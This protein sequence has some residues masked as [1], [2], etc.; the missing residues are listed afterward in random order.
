MTS[1]QEKL[2]QHRCHDTLRSRCFAWGCSHYDHRLDLRY[3]HLKTALFAG[4]RGRVLEIGAGAGVN[5]HYFT[6]QVEFLAVEPNPHMRKYLHRAA[7]EAGL[8][9]QIQAGCAEALPIEDNT[10]DT[11]ISTLVLCSVDD[12]QQ[13]LAEVR[14]VLKPG[15]QFCFIEHVAAPEG[16]FQNRLQHLTAPLWRFFGDGCNPHRKTGAAIEH[17]GFGQ[18]DYRHEQIPGVRLVSPHIVGFAK[19]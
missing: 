13:A 4:L 9:V 12:P 1:R 15:G 5:L 16:T 2:R 7:Q 8:K 11:V 6:E 17:A 18:V 3:A 14:R 19:K 10:I